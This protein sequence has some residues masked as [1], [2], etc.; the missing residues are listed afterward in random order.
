[1]FVTP[2]QYLSKFRNKEVGQVRGV[3]GRFIRGTD[4]SM[5]EFLSDEPHKKLSWVCSESLLSSI[6]GM[7]PTEALISIGKTPTWIENRSRDGTTHRLVVFPTQCATT[8]TWDNI[9]T[10]IREHYGHE[11]YLKLHLFQEPI[12]GITDF[13]TQIENASQ[14]SLIAELPLTQKIRH[15]QFM[16]PD[17]FLA[18][19]H[20]TLSDA[21]AFYYHCIGCNSRFRGNGM[22]IDGHLE[23][24]MPNKRIVDIPHAIQIPLEVTLEELKA[25]GNRGVII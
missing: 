19:P 13:N 15:S 4:E 2:L 5:F 25:I 3:I 10:L 11:L 8:A 9:L 14:I 6:L 23:M 22:S 21:R 7:T 12:K 17:K 24:L 20:P 18:L 16:T 1:M